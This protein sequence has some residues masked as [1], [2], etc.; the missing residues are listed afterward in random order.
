[1]SA[2]LYDS[3]CGAIK[4]NHAHKVSIAELCMFCWVCGELREIK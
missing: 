2:L 1:M 3:S 4:I